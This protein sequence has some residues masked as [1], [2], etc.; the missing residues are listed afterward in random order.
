MLAKICYPHTTASTN[1]FPKQHAVYV[2]IDSRLNGQG[3]NLC[4][5]GFFMLLTAD[6]ARSFRPFVNSGGGYHALNFSIAHNDCNSILA[7]VDCFIS[8]SGGFFVI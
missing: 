5:Q 2:D 4:G 7:Q 8:I 3:F 6:L 1:N